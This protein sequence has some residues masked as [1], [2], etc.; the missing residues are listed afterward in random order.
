M[1]TDATII[2]KTKTALL[3]NAVFREAPFLAGLRDLRKSYPGRSMI[4]GFWNSDKSGT[5]DVYQCY[6]ETDAATILDGAP[7]AGTGDAI[8]LL[9]TFAFVGAAASKGQRFLIPLVAPFVVVRY[10]NGG[11]NQGSFR[12]FVEVV[13]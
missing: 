8:T 10:T 2:A 12:L 6:D 9:D 11:A 7:A 13:E 1:S 4:R 5:L 3:A